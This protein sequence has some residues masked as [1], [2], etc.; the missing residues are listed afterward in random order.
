MV[1]TTIVSL[2]IGMKVLPVSTSPV[3]GH[4]LVRPVSRA[5]SSWRDARSDFGTQL[6]IPVLCGTFFLPL[7][8]FRLLGLPTMSLAVALGLEQ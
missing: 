3:S 7:V 4:E 1:S 5:S 6:P 8:F 2:G